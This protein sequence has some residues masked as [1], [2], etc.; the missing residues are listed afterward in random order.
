MGVSRGGRWRLPL[1]VS[2]AR[3]GEE[4]TRR[5]RARRTVTPLTSTGCWRVPDASDST[6]RWRKKLYD[7]LAYRNLPQD[8]RRRV[9]ANQRFLDSACPSR[10]TPYRALRPGNS[11]DFESA[12]RESANCFSATRSTLP[13]ALIGTWS[14]TMIS[15][16]AL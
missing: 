11:H 16:G 6:M 15:S 5:W 4:K 7:E 3:W 14:R 13:V 9:G 10:R 8:L 2:V 1:E 12:P